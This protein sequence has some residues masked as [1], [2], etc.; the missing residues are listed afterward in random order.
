MSPTFFDFLASLLLHDDP[1]GL[2]PEALAERRQFVLRL[3]QVTGPVTAKGLEDTAFYRYYPLAS[4]NEVGSHPAFPP[5]TREQFHERLTSQARDWPRTMLSS[6]TH[7][8]KRGE[9]LRARLSVLAEIPDRWQAAIERWQACNAAAKRELDGEP[10]PDANEEYLIYQTLVGTWPCEAAK[11]AVEP[12]YLDR[13]EAYF[14]KAF[15]E[16]KLHTSWLHPNAEYEQALTDF[17]RQILTAGEGSF[18]ADLD[19]LARSIADAGFVT[20]LAQ[21]LV[22]ICAPGVPDFYQGT[23]F[24]DFN[25]VDPDNRRPVDFAERREALTELADHGAAPAESAALWLGRWPDKR[26]KMF[27]LS[28]ALDWRR[29][30]SEFQQ[31]AYLPLAATGPQAERVV[32][33]ARQS[34]ESQSLCIVPRWVQSAL[35]QAESGG[36]GPQETWSPAR[37]WQGTRITLPPAAPRRWRHV[38]TGRVLS[39]SGEPDGPLILDLGEV[40]QDFPVALLATE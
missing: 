27:V 11:S 26:L 29:R 23:E 10:A 6:G 17:V 12:A 39:A 38:L 22:K 34:D 18:V 7:D 25:L 28:R 31:G 24:W 35:E 33:F 19:A 13:L 16:A 2:S 8:T 14:L 5:A 37:W 36:H 1:A 15:R 30:R 20:G 9:D 3:Q 4:L 21:L 40:W 32:A